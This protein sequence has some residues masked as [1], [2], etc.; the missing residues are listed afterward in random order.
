VEL[1][2]S[3]RP[4]SK[5]RCLN[6]IL[7]LRPIH[8]KPKEVKKAIT[9]NPAGSLFQYLALAYIHDKLVEVIG[10]TLTSEYRDVYH[11][12]LATQISISNKE[13]QPI[14]VSEASA[15]R[16]MRSVRKRL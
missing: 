4:R 1:E 5:C 9:P 8:D 3:Q 7:L 2:I 16:T 11:W 15:R 14:R 12:L 10:S 13:L 6:T